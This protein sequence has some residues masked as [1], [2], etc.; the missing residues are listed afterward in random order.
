MFVASNMMEKGI[1][2]VYPAQNYVYMVFV[3]V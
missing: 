2:I 3:C 1:A